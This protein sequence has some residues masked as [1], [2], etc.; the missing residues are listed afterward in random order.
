MELQTLNN[1]LISIIVVCYNQSQY[2]AHAL[3]SVFSQSYQQWECLIIDDGSTD[4]TE[5]IASQFTNKD[6]RF[7]YYK[8]INGGV[9]SARNLGL[10]NINGDFI[11]FLDADDLLQSD[12]IKTQ[13]DFL[14]I[15]PQIDIL[16]GTSRYFFDGDNEFYPTHFMGF[17]PAI[18]MHYL[19]KNQKDTLVV[20]NVSTICAALYRSTV[21]KKNIEFLPFPF[22]DFLFQIECGLKDFRFH[23]E[24]FKNSHCLIRMT[25]QSQM[26][27]HL[28]LYA[29]NNSFDIARRRLMIEHSFV[30]AFLKEP[31]L[32]TV[33]HYHNFTKS[34]IRNITPPIVM[35]L[36][37]WIKSLKN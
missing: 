21:L 18:E 25:E 27:E 11:Q 5:S 9:S 10:Q 16:Y 4:E 14:H 37:Y 22:E 23:F 26:Q 19:D 6:N 33:I 12:K 15:N 31:K 13:V 20:T 30:S 7:T 3:E 8:K 36:V 29:Q 1:K 32:E 24:R 17:A 2:L 35:K 34:L 28:N